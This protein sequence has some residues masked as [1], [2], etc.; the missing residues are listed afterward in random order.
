MEARLLKKSGRCR[1][2]NGSGSGVGGVRDVEA[3][4]HRRVAGEHW[5]Q[6]REE[7]Y[8]CCELSAVVGE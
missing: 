3:L 1:S 6:E 4:R 2:V 7:E 8:R 5:I